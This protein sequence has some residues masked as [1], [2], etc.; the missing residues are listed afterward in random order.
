M[1]ML[2]SQKCIAS[3][4]PQYIQDQHNKHINTCNNMSCAYTVIHTVKE[5]K[6]YIINETK[7]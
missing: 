5:Y 3:L 2:D 7:Y 6:A 1:I 4:S